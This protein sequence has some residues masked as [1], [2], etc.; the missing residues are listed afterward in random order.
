M[1]LN[2]QVK[3]AQRIG[4]VNA[5][6][7][8]MGFQPLQKVWHLWQPSCKMRVIGRDNLKGFTRR[9][10]INQINVEDGHR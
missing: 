10:V 1:H 8:T 2:T 4:E 3:Y 9:F 5:E 6:R 7:L